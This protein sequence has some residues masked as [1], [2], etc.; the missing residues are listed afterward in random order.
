VEWSKVVKGR[1]KMEGTKNNKGKMV[2]MRKNIGK[3]TRRSKIMLTMNK[4]TNT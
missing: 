4:K 3:P 1:I 2:S